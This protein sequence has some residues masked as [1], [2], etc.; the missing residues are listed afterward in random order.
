MR[1][2]LFFI[3]VAALLLPTSP[4]MAVSPAGQRYINQIVGGGSSSLR[5]ASQSIYNTENAE[6]KVLDVLSEKLLQTYNKPGN[7]NVDAT[8][9]ACKALGQSRDVRYKNVLSTVVNQ[10]DNRKFKNMQ[11]NH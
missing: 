7:T 5:R 1:K 4:A 11:N 10:A 3:I 6:R 9:W 2:I 8:A